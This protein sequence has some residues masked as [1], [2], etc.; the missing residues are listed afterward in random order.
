MQ[1]K[2]SPVRI[3][4]IV[5]DDP[6]L[7][8]SLERTF[9]A[10][11]L[12][13]GLTAVSYQTASAFLDAAPDLSEGCLLLDIIMPEMDG[14]ELQERLNSLGFNMPVIVMTAWGDVETA[15]QAMKSGAVDFIEKPFNDEALLDAINAALALDR[16]PTRDRESVVA[17]K[18]MAKLS[19][20]ERQV[21]DGLVGGSSTK[22]IAYDLGIS[23]RTV[24]VHRARML[25]RLGT[26]SLAEAIRL[27]VLAGLPPADLEAN[28]ADRQRLSGAS[29]RLPE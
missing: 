26:H 15:V 20:R 14:L 6:A 29:R 5:D 11:G 12:T 3:V 27:A 23:A 21:L 8:G 9:R 16:G 17:S 22:Q 1:S 18:L 24:E 25:A 28:A 7:L 2:G 4:Y 13:A 19:P 10:A